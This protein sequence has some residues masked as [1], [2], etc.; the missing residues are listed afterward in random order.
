[1]A[2]ILSWRGGKVTE[3]KGIEPPAPS[4][5]GTWQS[6]LLEAAQL[7]DETPPSPPLPHA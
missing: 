2:E 7:G 6:L 4:L 1:L 3:T 5:H